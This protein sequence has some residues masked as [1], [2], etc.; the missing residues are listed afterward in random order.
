M[1]DIPGCISTGE[2]PEEALMMIKE[3]MELH[4]ES[5]VSDGELVPPSTPIEKIAL[6]NEYQDCTWALA[7]SVPTALP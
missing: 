4:I 7:A 2:T 1:P 6:S 3:A 5:T